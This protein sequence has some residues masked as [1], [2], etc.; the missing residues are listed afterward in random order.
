M[1][2]GKNKWNTLYQLWPIIAFNNSVQISALD[3][4]VRWGVRMAC[5][6][7]LVM[8]ADCQLINFSK[9]IHCAYANNW[10]ML[11]KNNSTRYIFI[12]IVLHNNVYIYVIYKMASYGKLLL[13]NIFIK[14]WPR[15]ETIYYIYFYKH[16]RSCITGDNK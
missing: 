16:S 13:R 3:R 11:K 4:L 15:T 8:I 5:S 6:S 10:I 2:Y 7:H 14:V 12:N 9:A 1:L